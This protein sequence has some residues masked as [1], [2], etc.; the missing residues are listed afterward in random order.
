VGDYSIADI[1]LFR[2]YFRMTRTLKP[3]ADQ[4]PQLHAH[5]KRMLKRPAVLRTCEI[6]AALGYEYPGLT[7]LSKD[8]LAD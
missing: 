1:H 8:D 4:F 5:Y 2:L 3:A 7:P 6:E